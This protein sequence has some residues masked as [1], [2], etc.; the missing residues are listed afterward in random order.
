MLCCCC[1]KEKPELVIGILHALHFFFPSPISRTLL[2]LSP[3]PL[4]YS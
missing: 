3:F 4:A 2:E 1:I